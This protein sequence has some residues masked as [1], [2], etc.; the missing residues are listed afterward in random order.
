MSSIPESQ[1]GAIL[2][3]DLGALAGNYRML[4]GK[5]KPGAKLA[6]VVKADGYGVG[7][8]EAGPALARAGCLDFFVARLS[9]GVALRKSLSGEERIFVLDGPFEG[10]ER[11]F[12]Q[13]RLIPVL[14]SLE[15]VAGWNGAVGKAAPA[16]LHVDTGMN[17]LGLA[18]GEIDALLPLLSGL[19][20]ILL[21]SHLAR[22]EEP[23]VAMNGEQLAGFDLARARLPGLPSSLA[24]S[25]GIFLGAGYHFD[26]A[27]AGA[28]LYGVN[29]TPGLA[30]PMAQVVHLQGR[31]V[32]VRDVDTPATVGYGATH[33][34]RGK[35]RIAAVSVGYADGW[36][37]ALGNRGAGLVGGTR[38]PLVGRVSMDLITFD[39]TD[40]PRAMAAPGGFVT[41]LG[42]DLPV[43][44]VAD[45]AGTIGYEILTN[46]GRRYHRRLAGG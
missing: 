35:R 8:A 14:N 7:A 26:M 23:D 4:A 17:R 28:A 33:A 22:S 45:A 40:A 38:V 27:R 36:P 46:L 20:L 5:L 37:R 41:L 24:N 15:Q 16:A 43:D 1:A 19:D 25:S 30:N 34:V 42:P 44:E 10:T 32:Q 9:E 29:P 18:L 2:T 11:E 39:V 6:A 13:H 21:M 31:I 3:L 12:P